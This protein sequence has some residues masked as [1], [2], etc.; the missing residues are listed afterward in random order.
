MSL[1]SLVVSLDDYLLCGVG[2]PDSIIDLTDSFDS[3]FE[4]KTG[5]LDSLGFDYGDSLSS[6]SNLVG[7][8]IYLKDSLGL[9]KNDQQLI[10]NKFPDILNLSVVDDGSA[11]NIHAKTSYYGNVLGINHHELGNIIKKS[12]SI[13]GYS[14]V[15]DGRET[16]LRSKVDFYVND[17]GLLIN[18]FTDLIKQSPSILGYAIKTN[19][20]PKV[21]YLRLKNKLSDY[22]ITSIT[23]YSVKRFCKMVGVPE[24][25]YVSFKNKW[26]Y[27]TSNRGSNLGLNKTTLDYKQ[28]IDYSK[29]E[30]ER[31]YDEI[32]NNGLINDLMSDPNLIFNYARIN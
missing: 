9:V 19:V 11:S 21:Y 6:L 31:A 7:L 22:K 8:F 12:P 29:Q 20:E 16:N 17:Y 3:S 4:S 30:L 18:D 2:D 15:D 28:L 32:T 10:V 13:L 25:D 1:E 26:V 27:L 14:V 23:I 24:A 5:F